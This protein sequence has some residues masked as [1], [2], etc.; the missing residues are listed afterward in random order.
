MSWYRYRKHDKDEPNRA[1]PKTDTKMIEFI[2]DFEMN[3]KR[4]GRH[5]KH[6]KKIENAGGDVPE[7][8]KEIGFKKFPRTF[9]WFETKWNPYTNPK[10]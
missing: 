3:G 8:L 10:Y 7:G 1:F 9:F 2:W 4:K 6:N 5:S